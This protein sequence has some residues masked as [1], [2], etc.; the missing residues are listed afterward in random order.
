GGLDPLAA[1]TLAQQVDQFVRVRRPFRRAE[2]EP[3]VA[4]ATAIR[5]RRRWRVDAVDA[6][7]PARKDASR[8]RVGQPYPEDSRKAENLLHERQLLLLVPSEAAGS[9]PG[10]RSWCLFHRKKPKGFA[11]VLT[12]SPTFERHD[13]GDE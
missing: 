11:A 2:A 1:I 6:A 13:V 7:A 10:P 12:V 5:A 4:R 3:F 8:N 9:K